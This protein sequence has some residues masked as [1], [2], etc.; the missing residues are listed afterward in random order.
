VSDYITCFRRES[1]GTWI[2]LEPVTIEHPRGRIQI[3]PGSSFC[4]GNKFMGVDL[5]AWLDQQIVEACRK[6]PQPS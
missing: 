6:R 4:K 5:A 3:A 2:C 1:G